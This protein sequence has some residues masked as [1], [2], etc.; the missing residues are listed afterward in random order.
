MESALKG[1]GIAKKN[2]VASQP[3]LSKEKNTM[4]IAGNHP[5]AL[6]MVMPMT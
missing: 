5:H 4:K 2:L 1:A 6:M 3:K